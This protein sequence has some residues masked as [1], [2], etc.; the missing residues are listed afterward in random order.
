[1]RILSTIH[2]TGNAVVL[3]GKGLAV[4]SS[5]LDMLVEL[6]RSY[7]GNYPKFFKMDILCKLG[8]IASELLLKDDPKRF[9]P[10]S[11]RAVLMFSRSGSI[12]ND[13]NYMGTVAGDEYF[14]SPSLFVYT[15][16]NIV[17]G[18][19]AIR[20][21]YRGDTTAFELPGYDARAIE[22]NLRA[23][24]LDTETTSALCGWLE[25]SSNEDFEA[26]ISI[27]EKE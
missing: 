21:L 27:I 24:F 4:S 20:N 3:N 8:F 22:E 10:R 16:A 13:R 11:D 2:I 17:T 23:A 1:M 12:C 18:E 9:I 26:R 19:L 6:Y 5:G 15:L 14:P 25:C 7:V